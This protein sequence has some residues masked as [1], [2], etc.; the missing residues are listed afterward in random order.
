MERSGRNQ[1]APPLPTISL[2][3]PSAE[4]LRT[5]DAELER[6]RRRLHAHS[7]VAVSVRERLAATLVALTAEE[8]AQ[9]LLERLLQDQPGRRAADRLDRIVLV[10]DR[11]RVRGESSSEQPG[12]CLGQQTGSKRLKS[13]WLNHAESNREKPENPHE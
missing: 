2:Q 9:L 13:A 12:R 8:L 3:K 6:A 1:C 5:R 10:A 11:V 7:L 4:T